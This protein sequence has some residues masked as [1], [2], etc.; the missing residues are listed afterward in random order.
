VIKGVGASSDGKGKGLTA[1]NA[2]GQLRSLE[3]AYEHAGFAADSVSLIEA[4]GTGTV[5]GDRTE[6]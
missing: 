6:A 3:R 5:V 2:A 1:P 4:H